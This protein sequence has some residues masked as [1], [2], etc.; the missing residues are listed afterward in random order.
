MAEAGAAQQE[1]DEERQAGHIREDAGQSGP[2]CLP[3]VEAPDSKFAPSCLQAPMFEVGLSFSE[4]MKGCSQMVETEE[5]TE[6]SR[7]A[8]APEKVQNE[9]LPRQPKKRG[10]M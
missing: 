1:G 6:E 9:D 7:T 8:Q 3:R 2:A 4:D 5:R 10:K